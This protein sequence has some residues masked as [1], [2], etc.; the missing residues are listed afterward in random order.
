MSDRFACRSAIVRLIFSSVA[1]YHHV[2]ADLN[3]DFRCDDGTETVEM[4]RNVLICA[5]LNAMTTP[6]RSASDGRSQTQPFQLT[7]NPALRVEFQGSRVTS[8]AGLILVRELDERSGFGGLI[9][10]HLTDP[11]ATNRDTAP[12]RTSNTRCR[13]AENQRAVAASTPG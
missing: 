3:P 12:E 5:S 9:A 7:F 2:D 1:G 8:D 4:C 10:Q 6:W 13:I 11:R